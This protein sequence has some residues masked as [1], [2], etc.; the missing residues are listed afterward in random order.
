[1]RLTILF[2]QYSAY[3]TNQSLSNSLQISPFICAPFFTHS[4]FNTGTGEAVTVTM[5]SASLTASAAVSHAFPDIL[6][7]KSCAL[8]NVRLHTLTLTRNN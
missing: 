4:L 7:A 3:F 6:L 8:E 5:M 1:M 2:L